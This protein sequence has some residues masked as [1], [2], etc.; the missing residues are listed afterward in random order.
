MSQARLARELVARSRRNRLRGYLELLARKM[1]ARRLA[2]MALNEWEFRTRRVKLRSLPPQ[3][4]LDVTNYC[5]LHCPL[6][7]TGARLHKAL[8]QRIDLQDAE[9]IM[10]RFAAH[11]FHVFLYCW[12]EPLLHPELPEIVR[13]AR[14]MNLAVTISSNLQQPLSLDRAR[15]LVAAGPDVIV[16][17]IDG[18]TQAVYEHYRAGGSLETALDGL[19]KLRQARDELGLDRPLLEWQTLL[20]RHNLHQAPAIIGRYRELGADRLSFESPNLPFDMADGEQAQRWLLDPGDDPTSRDVKD[21][22]D[23]ACWWPYRSAII[24]VDG[25][26]SPCCYVYG[27]QAQWGNMLERD[28]AQIWNSPKFVALRSVFAHP[29]SPPPAPC[30]RCSVTRRFAAGVEPPVRSNR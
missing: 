21:N 26:I 27:E 8:P 14:S 12:G 3:I 15:E 7:A 25:S 11:S 22:V 5:N 2:N 1:T 17:S 6:C 30:D 20:F 16:A 4:T 19:A 29:G 28:F 18:L 23:G 10:A 9:R 13:I 24:G